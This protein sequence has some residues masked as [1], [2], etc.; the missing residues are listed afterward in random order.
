MSKESKFEELFESF[1]ELYARYYDVREF[2]RHLDATDTEDGDDEVEVY[3]VDDT[4]VSLQRADFLP[5]I[6]HLDV[7]L[8]KLDV[9]L[10][11]LLVSLDQ[12]GMIK[13]FVKKHIDSD[14]EDFDEEFKQK[15]PLLSR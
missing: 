8:A 2:K 9:K 11:A 12:M 4:Q 5:L 1:D 3:L 13:N 7:I 10:D 6:P 15:H 14:G